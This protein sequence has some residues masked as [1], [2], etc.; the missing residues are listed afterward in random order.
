MNNYKVTREGN[1][2][3]EFTK[4]GLQTALDEGRLLVT[5]RALTVGMHEAESLAELGF[6]PL[7]ESVHASAATEPP[8]FK[9]ALIALGVA[10][11]FLSIAVC[12]N[13]L[14]DG[15][16]SSTVVTL[17][18][19]FFIVALKGRKAWA[20]FILTVILGLM[21]LPSL[22]FIAAIAKAPAPLLLKIATTS[23][24]ITIIW[25]FSVFNRRDVRVWCNR[26]VS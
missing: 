12:W 3:G 11:V 20:H 13:N 18:C 22:F 6:K 23:F 19:A 4:D 14:A 7:A 26:K 16:I 5:D 25:L 15:W 2:L 9:K 8:V 1:L 21:L 24:Y 10:P 17:L